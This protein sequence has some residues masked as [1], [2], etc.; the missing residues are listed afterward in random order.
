MGQGA[1]V[2]DNG[3]TA[4]P[5]LVDPVDQV[6]LVVGLKAL[7]LDTQGLSLPLQLPVNVRQRGRP[8]DLRF[9]CAGQVEIGTVQ[10]KNA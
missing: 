2:D 1:G 5:G 6:T 10:H 8:I 3:V 9:P 7:H 4:P